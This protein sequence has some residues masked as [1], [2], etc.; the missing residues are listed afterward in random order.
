[1][2]EY[3]RRLIKF[4]NYSLCVTLPKAM[5]DKLQL[6]KGDEVAIKMNRGKIIV[7]PNGAGL[8]GSSK[9]R[10]RA[11]ESWEPIPELGKLPP[12]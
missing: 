9:V 2:K 8:T 3:R 10:P 4:S 7:E 1:M 12:S 6:G 5:L 11:A